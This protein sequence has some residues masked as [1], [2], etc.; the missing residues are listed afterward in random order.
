MGKNVVPIV[1]EAIL[2]DLGVGDGKI[3][4]D[5][6]ADTMQHQI[7]LRGMWKK[8]ASALAQAQPL[9]NFSEWA[10]AM[11]SGLGTASLAIG[12]TGIVVG[13]IVAVNAVGDVF[14]HRTGV[15]VAGAYSPKE[16]KFINTIGKLRDG[17]SVA[18]SPGPATNTTI[19]RS[20]HQCPVG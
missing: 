13:A 12:N 6:D 14:D 3:R 19:G 4:P 9:E 15:I 1:P 8:E 10:S 11:K 5:A 17:Y 7:L 16:R 18:I 20:R 2:Y